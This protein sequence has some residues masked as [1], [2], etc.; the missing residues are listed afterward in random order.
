MKDNFKYVSVKHMEV[1]VAYPL[2]DGVTLADFKDANG[3]IDANA[4]FTAFCVA[5]LK[6]A[7]NNTDGYKG[8]AFELTVRSILANRLVTSLYTTGSV[9]L[10]SALVGRYFGLNRSAVIEVKTACGAIPLREVDAVFYC[11]EVDASAD[12]LT[13][14]RVFSWAE[15]TDFINGY[16]GRGQFLKV[17]RNEY[18]IQSFYVSETKRPKASKPIANYINRICDSKATLAEIMDR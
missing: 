9:D 11:P 14:A 10:T 13:Q 7:P 6:K 17:T 2:A 4:L 16:D 18:H 5:V 1:K 3:N 8:I 12:I 15:W